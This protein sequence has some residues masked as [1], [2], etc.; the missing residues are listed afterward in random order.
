MITEDRN[1]PKD[2]KKTI[3]RIFPQLGRKKILTVDLYGRF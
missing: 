1:M 3:L 2:V